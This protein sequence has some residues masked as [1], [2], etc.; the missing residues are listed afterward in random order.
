MNPTPKG[1]ALLQDARLADL[2]DEL[3]NS[4]DHANPACVIQL[5]ATS[6]L[7]S[8]SGMRAKGVIP[9]FLVPL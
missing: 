8:Q 2:R 7:R 1:V 9:P 5:L 6:V 4:L 3:Q